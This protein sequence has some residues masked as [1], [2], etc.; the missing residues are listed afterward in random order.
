ME[1]VGVSKCADSGASLEMS[2]K[3]TRCPFQHPENNGELSFPRSKDEL[4][5]DQNALG[6][7]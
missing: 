2:P 5:D 6:G 4:I 7:Q 1:A 3:G